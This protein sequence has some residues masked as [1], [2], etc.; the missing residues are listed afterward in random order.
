MA[1]QRFCVAT[2]NGARVFFFFVLLF[3]LFL[4]ILRACVCACVLTGVRVC[5]LNMSS[6]PRRKYNHKPN[7]IINEVKKKNNNINE[8][9]QRKERKRINTIT[10]NWAKHANMSSR[11][12]TRTHTH[13]HQLARSAPSASSRVPRAL[14]VHS[15]TNFSNSNFFPIRFGF[16]SVSLSFILPFERQRV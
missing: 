3:S 9:K 1:R 11:T 2:K 15:N 16:L 13:T 7:A 8:T 12:L 14:A 5:A 10:T 4:T 6:R